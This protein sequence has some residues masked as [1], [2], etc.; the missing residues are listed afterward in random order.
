M[1]ERYLETGEVVSTHGIRG[2]L[3]IYPWADSPEFLLQLKELRIGGRIY[4]VTSSRVQ[5]TCVLVKLQ[6]VDSIEAAQPL[7]GKTVEFNRDAYAPETGW[8]IAD[9]I[10]LE[11]RCDGKVIGKLKDVLQM[12]GN[13]VWV[14]KGTHEYLIPSVPEFILKVDPANGFIEVRL[15]EGMASDEN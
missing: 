12:P 7:I 2:E 10:G 14:V 1:S 11:V 6:G 5:K 4:P 15:L 3:K 8:Y 9:L 13:D